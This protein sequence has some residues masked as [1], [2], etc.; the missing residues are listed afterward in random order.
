MGKVVLIEIQS[1]GQRCVIPSFID[2][3]TV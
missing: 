1:H 3:G 2:L